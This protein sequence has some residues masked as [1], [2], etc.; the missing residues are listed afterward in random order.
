M[1]LKGVKTFF[2][3]KTNWL[4][5]LLIIFGF[6]LRIYN[7]NHT[8]YYTMDEEVMNLIQ[9]RIALGIH[10]PLIGSVSPLSTYL[11]PYWYYIGALILG[12]SKLNPV[13]QGYFAALLG[14][15]NIWLIYIVGKEMF[16]KKVGLFASLFYSGSF[17]M[18]LFDRRFWQLTLGPVLSLLVLLSLYKIKKGSLKFIYLLVA[19]IIL[20][21]N[22]DYT[23]LVLILFTIFCWVIF[24]LPIRKK[25][26]GIAVIIFILSCAP[27]A[28]FDLRH[29]FLNTKAFIG[30]FTHHQ[31]KLNEG[32][33]VTTV[34]DR[35]TLGKTNTDQAV[36]SS[37][38]PI[39]GFSRLIF[40]A[41]DPNLS[42]QYTYCKQYINQRNAAQGP[43]LLGLSLVFI[44]GFLSLAFKK[45]KEKDSLGYKF[46]VYFYLIFQIGILGYAFLL[47]GDVFEHYLS[48]LLPYFV[49]MLA[50]SAGFLWGKKLQLLVVVLILF[51]LG[52]NINLVFRSYNPY[53]FENKMEAAQFAID[54]VGNSS[55]SLESIGSCY[56]YDGYY[57][58]FIL[59]GSHPV[60]SYQDGNYSWLYDY[61]V[62]EKDPSKV[63]VMV[64]KGQFED[65][66]FFETYNRY[67]KWVTSR[68]T[69]GG[70]EVLILD[71]SRGDFH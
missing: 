22:A 58:P 34:S 20:G 19:A 17:L 51:F 67:Q 63:V 64:S 68:K 25:E 69:F 31:Q 4:L 38:V 59:Q 37:L 1:Q 54:R 41:S 15:F 65:Q 36:I 60:K 33:N 35:E 2:Q 24:K 7:L 48:T 13:G 11:G 71:N 50:V 49:L 21:F 3:D 42:A 32:V 45:W 26:V 16:S 70:L 27:L 39:Y 43:L 28:F 56:R 52:L 5:P 44:V 9:R 61:K 30:Y 10:L 47:H 40:T 53:S 23:N 55:Y 18:V 57:Y 29:N 12:I 62:A 8:L 14:T 6:L 46:L 66:N